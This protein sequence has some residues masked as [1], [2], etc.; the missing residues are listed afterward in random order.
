MTGGATVRAVH[1]VTE[2]QGN[3]E[4]Y[5]LIMGAIMVMIISSLQSV[6]PEGTTLRGVTCLNVATCQLHSLLLRGSPSK[7]KGSSC[8]QSVI[9]RA[10]IDKAFPGKLTCTI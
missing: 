6:N 2:L 4:M 7:M 5:H 9:I 8:M 1:I 3:M 10:Y